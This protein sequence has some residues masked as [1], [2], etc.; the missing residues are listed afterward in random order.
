LK[1]ETA[2]F[3]AI[4]GAITAF[5]LPFAIAFPPTGLLKLAAIAALV[6]VAVGITAII[7]RRKPHE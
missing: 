4:A 3:L 7:R 6:L 5:G 1:P 2:T